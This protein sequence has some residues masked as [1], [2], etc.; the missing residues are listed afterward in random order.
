M[1]LSYDNQ[2]TEYSSLQRTASVVR[3]GRVRVSLARRSGD[4]GFLSC[5]LFCTIYWAIFVIINNEQ[6]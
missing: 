6:K 2:I 4:H 3:L 1:I 5:T